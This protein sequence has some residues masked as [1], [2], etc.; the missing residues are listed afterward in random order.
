[1]SDGSFVLSNG[2]RADW[3][4]SDDDGGG[5]TIPA[6]ILAAVHGDDHESPKDDDEFE[7][8]M[9]VT[10]VEPTVCSSDPAGQ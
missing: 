8:S 7:S 10:T 4:D 2:E 1:M 3:H 9:A 6:D 5:L